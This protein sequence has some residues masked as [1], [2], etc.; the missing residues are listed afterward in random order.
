MLNCH[1]GILALY[2][3]GLQKAI[4]SKYGR[5]LLEAFPRWRK[6]FGEKGSIIE[7]YR[8]LA[9]ELSNS[10]YPDYKVIADKLPGISVKNLTRMGQAYILY[11]VRDIRTWV[12]KVA[13]KDLYVC[14]YDIVPAVIDYTICLASSFLYIPENRLMHV[15]FNEFIS[16]ESNVESGVCKFLSI[17]YSE[18]MSK[19]WENVGR[20]TKDDKVKQALQWLA[21]HPSAM[22][23]PYAQDT[24]VQI[25]EHKFWDAFL[26]IFDFY[27]T[28]LNKK[29][30]AEKITCD[31]K[32]LNEYRA[33]FSLPFKSAYVTVESRTLKRPVRAFKKPNFLPLLKRLAKKHTS[34]F[35]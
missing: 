26:P 21:G 28:R 27:Y 6:L 11:M 12:A 23:K 25:A 16:S 24:V 33:K 14:R 18:S 34:K 29:I 1:P 13:V 9:R 22:V 3:V 8:Q 19:W 35:V 31:I 15:N 2:E 32:A 7:N 30:D 20:C 17:P 4:P 10:E 5:Q